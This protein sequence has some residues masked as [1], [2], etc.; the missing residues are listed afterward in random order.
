LN[1]PFTFL[2]YKYSYAW[3]VGEIYY[4][5][6]QNTIYPLTS[7]NNPTIN[8]G[9]ASFPATNRG[10]FTANNL[11]R[12]GSN[13]TPIS[14][15]YWSGLIWTGIDPSD[16]SINSQK[17]VAPLGSMP[18]YGQS[19][20]QVNEST[21]GMHLN[22]WGLQTP[23]P[24]P[25]SSLQY[26]SMFNPGKLP[27]TNSSSQL[28]VNG[29]IDLHS[30]Y[31]PTGSVVQVMFTLLFRKAD[32][33]ARFFFVNA[34]ILDTQGQLNDQIIHDLTGANG[35]GAPIVLTYVQTNNLPQNPSIQYSSTIPGFGLVLSS[36][37]SEK[38]NPTSTTSNPKPYGFCISNTQFSNMLSGMNFPGVPSNYKL[39]VALVSPE[40][41]GYAN[42]G[43]SI[44]AL[45][46]YRIVP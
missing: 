5:L 13:F 46:V 17:G 30:W 24:Y 21:V 10:F 23:N 1:L 7:S 39:E 43:L 42:A 29:L 32:D 20:V 38:S 28:C 44:H 41:H 45:N 6:N 35:T 26:V 40:I 34:L 37:R 25:T 11:V 16:R 9:V 27:W 22:T 31:V 4:S 18:S 8:N 14:P 15:N 12:T 36:F 19:L 2:A 3:T 33:P